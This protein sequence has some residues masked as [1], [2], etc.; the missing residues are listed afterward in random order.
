MK[1]QT[2]SLAAGGILGLVFLCLLFAFQV[3]Q[4][5]VAVVTTFGKASSV[6]EEPG[7]YFRLPWPIHRI[8]RFDNR[9]RDF[10]RKFEQTTTS[11]ARTLLITVY[12]GWR[13]ADPGIFLQRFGGSVSGV[14]RNLENLVR[15]AKNAVIGQHPFSDLINTRA[16]DLKFGEIEGEMLEAIR[17]PARENYG[18]EVEMVGIKR[19]GLPESITGKVFERMREERMRLVKRYQGEGEAQAIRIR[20]EA[21]QERRE[22]LARAE[23]EATIMIGEAEAEAAQYY[24]ELDKDPQLANYLLRLRTLTEATAEKTTLILDPSTP[25]FDLLQGLGGALPGAPPPEAPEAAP[26]EAG[27]A[28]AR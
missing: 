3:R 21:D 26:G 16:E 12:L 6:K 23:A 15:D 25:P 5:E 4:T 28:P 18:I 17:G 8:Y 10:E 27:A 22:I 20:A 9:L 14:E 7:L 11:D 24:Q 13:I 19:L 2:I 1:K